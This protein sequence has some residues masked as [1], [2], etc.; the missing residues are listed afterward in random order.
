MIFM[1]DGEFA[2]RVNEIA[3]IRA[4]ARPG[5]SSRCTARRMAALSGTRLAEA[6]GF[7]TPKPGIVHS[8]SSTSEAGLKA[9]LRDC[10]V[11]HSVKPQGLSGSGP[12]T[13]GSRGFLTCTESLYLF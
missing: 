13:N 1:T 5:R 4:L 11:Q 12:G 10:I 9:L 6:I 2:G 3:K 8:R 7:K